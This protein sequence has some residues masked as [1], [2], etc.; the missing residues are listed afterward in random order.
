MEIMEA[1]AGVEAEVPSTGILDPF[2][3]TRK[4]VPATP[5][6]GKPR[7]YLLKKEVGGMSFPWLK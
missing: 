2:Q 7:P 3:Y 4:S 5:T 6:S 1:M